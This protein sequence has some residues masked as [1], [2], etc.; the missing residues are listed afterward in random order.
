VLTYAFTVW[1]ADVSHP[2]WFGSAYNY[3][4][5]SISSISV[6]SESTVASTDPNIALSAEQQALANSEDREIY[7]KGT[8]ALGTNRSGAYQ[9]LTND[10]EFPSW[11]KIYT[12]PSTPWSQSILD[13]FKDTQTYLQQVSALASQLAASGQ[14]VVSQVMTDPSKFFGTLTK[15]L[16][17]AAEQFASTSNLTTAIQNAALSWLGL[18][19]FKLPDLTNLTSALLSYAGLTVDNLKSMVV[20]ALGANN[21]LVAG[22]V[23]QLFNN[24]PDNLQGLQTIF[25]NFNNLINSDNLQL[26]ALN[27]ATIETQI[28]TSFE[29]K[30]A[31]A[32]V[33]AVGNLI[34]K[35]VPGAGAVSSLISGFGFLFN[36]QQQIA[37][38]VQDFLNT[39]GELASGNDKAFANSLVKV[40]DNSLPL[41]LKLAASQL[42]LGSL[43]QQIQNALSIIP[44][45]VQTQLMKVLTALASKLPL[46]GLGGGGGLFAG[47]LAPLVKV[48]YQGVVYDLWVAKDGSKAVVKVAVDGTQ[49]LLTALTAANLSASV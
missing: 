19:N 14:Q 49:K 41:L 3:I 37:N 47:E 44:N 38:V 11:I 33:Q 42:G 17:S 16:A 13:A 9:F 34:A 27:L 40:L 4:T 32:A 26:P 28:Q 18:Q 25:N 48:A 8:V 2:S 31:T 45:T 1:V 43:P 10:S 29:Q 39:A 7:L 30:L 6:L 15:G 5:G 24:V 21:A 23:A 36:N 20:Q 22:V 12:P 35:F 46:S